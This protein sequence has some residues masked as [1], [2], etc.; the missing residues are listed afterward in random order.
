[1]VTSGNYCQDDKDSQ[2]W[3]PT[4]E[5]VEYLR[6]TNRKLRSLISS[7]ENLPTVQIRLKSR[8]V[9]AIA[10]SNEDT[11]SL[12]SQVLELQQKLSMAHKELESVRRK[13][14]DKQVQD[15]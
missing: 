15:S 7:Q 12:N 10:M 9:A 13:E 3:K 2:C 4:R 1:M 5:S 6:M 14:A 8:K 11:N